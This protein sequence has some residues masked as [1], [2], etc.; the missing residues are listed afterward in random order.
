MAHKKAGSSTAL[1]RDSQGKRLGVKLSGGSRA[2]AGAI[3]I[4]QRGTK[5]HPGVNVMKGKDDTLFARIAGIVR[6]EDRK[7]DNFHGVPRRIKIVN[8]DP[9]GKATAKAPSAA[10]SKPVVKK[11]ATAK[12]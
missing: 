7:R 6:F 9:L 2:K 11:L 5:I 3:I 10:K 8:I 1:G 12:K 4:R